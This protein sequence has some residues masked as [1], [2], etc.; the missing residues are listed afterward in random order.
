MEHGKVGLWSTNQTNSLQMR[1]CRIRNV[2][3]DG[4]NLA[5]GTSHSTVTQTHVRNSGD[6]AMAMWSETFNNVNNA[7]TY[8][9]IQLPSL[10]NGIAI[11]GGQNNRVTNNLIMDIV[12]NG[13]GISFGTNFAPPSITGTLT[14]SN[15]ALVRAGSWHHD[16]GYGIG[17]IWAY[18]LGSAGRIASPAITVSSNVITDS[19]YPGILIEEPSTGASQ[20]FSGN[21]IT[22]VGTYGVQIKSTAAG[23]ATFNSNTVNGSAP[24]GRFIN[25]ST[26]LTVSGSG[27]NW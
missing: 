6:D 12:D 13:A 16:Y 15:N 20:T 14:I 8:N 4:L 2:W 21:S 10:A 24:S 5:R 19:S 22:N 23:T 18:W 7:F 1:E 11:Y 25:Q 9:T 17:A 3:A 26:A 27:N